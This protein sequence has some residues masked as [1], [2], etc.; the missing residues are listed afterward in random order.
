MTLYL[1]EGFLLIFR[2]LGKILPEFP[3]TLVALSCSRL[4]TLLV[5]ISIEV[6]EA[7]RLYGHGCSDKGHGLALFYALERRGHAWGRLRARLR[8][9]PLVGD[10]I[11][12]A[13]LRAYCL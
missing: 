2:M 13:G 6:K 1:L 3:N 5:H 4:F 12:E 8:E 10:G 11:V 7:C 9:Y